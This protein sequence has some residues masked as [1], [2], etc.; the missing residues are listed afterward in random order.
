MLQRF[1]QKAF[2]GLALLLASCQSTGTP[3]GT[4][5]G[6]TLPMPDQ[7]NIIRNGDLR[8]GP[9]DT[10]HVRVF[11]VDELDGDYQ[12]DALGNIKMPLVS[13]VSAQG[14]TAFEFAKVLE[15]RLGETYLQDPDV[16]VSIVESQGQEITIE[17]AVRKP[18]VYPVEGQL[19]LLQAIAISG[20]PSESAN[21]RKV[22]IFRVID[23]EKK[24][25]VFDLKAIRNH[26]MEDPA[27]YG[28]DIIVM[29]GS[30]AQQTYRE[31][32]RS[33]PL[34]GLFLAL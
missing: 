28:N 8:I 31:V 33:I 12:V 7:T 18:G 4:F 13:E 25:A 1:F 5:S 30:E 26:K 2:L 10:L 6:D 29:D 22:A 16:T 15:Q 19:S 20:G 17:G 9:L 24:A 23:G 21:P 34:I 3:A 14:Y 11:G 27:V 32:I